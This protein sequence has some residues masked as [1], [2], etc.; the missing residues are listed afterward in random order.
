MPSDIDLS[1]WS[2]MSDPIERETPI[3]YAQLGEPLILA[4]PFVMLPGNL[5][6]IVMIFVKL[7]QTQSPF[8]VLVAFV[9]NASRGNVS[10]GE[11]WDAIITSPF[12]L[13]IPLAAWTVRLCF[14]PIAGKSERAVVSS[15]SVASMTMT[16]LAAGYCVVHLFK[17]PRF[18]V[19][20][21]GSLVVLA[22]FLL[23][24]W[25]VS[26]LRSTYLPALVV[27]T[28]AFATNLLLTVLLVLTNPSWASGLMIGL[29]IGVTQLLATGFMVR[30][31]TRA[32]IL[33]H[34]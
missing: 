25:K 34:G 17:E 7:T 8:D 22:I 6:A 9:R 16:L 4:K 20:G 11:F 26:G 3:S 18:I 21:L 33:S 10:S 30:K 15:L 19:P 13:S 27:I 23:M 32:A 28:G 14:N 29:L 24:L 1:F 31:Y 12:L 5:A 2:A